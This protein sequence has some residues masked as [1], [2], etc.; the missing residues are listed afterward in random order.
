MKTF[1]LTAKN[2]TAKNVKKSLKF[3]GKVYFENVP[4]VRKA[5]ADRM[6]EILTELHRKAKEQKTGI[7]ATK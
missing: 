7:Y 5:V 6:H 3:D 1:K 2:L 4:E